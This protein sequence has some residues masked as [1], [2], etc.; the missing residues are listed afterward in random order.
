MNKTMP[1]RSTVVGDVF[2]YKYAF[3][4]TILSKIARGSSEFSPDL[5]ILSQ[6]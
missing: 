3:Q 5:A 4:S 6:K 1:D 2:Y